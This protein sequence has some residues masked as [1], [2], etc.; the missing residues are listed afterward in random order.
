MAPAAVVAQVGEVTVVTDTLNVR[1]GP[2]T[3][4]PIIGK[5]TCGQKVQPNGKTADGSWWRIPFS[6]GNGFVFAQFATA[7]GTCGNPAAAA[8]PAAAPAAAPV[9]TTGGGTNVSV[10]SATLNVRSGPGL[11][12][13]ILGKLTQGQAIQATGKTTDGQWLQIVYNNGK[14]F[15]YA[16]YT[17]FATGT[18][19]PAPA[20]APAGA[21]PET[22]RGFEVRPPHP[23]QQEFPHLRPPMNVAGNSSQPAQARAPQASTLRQNVSPFAEPRKPV[24]APK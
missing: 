18:T 21:A 7:G 11:T 9:A 19:A 23:P 2:S 12:Y 6:N 5:L 16:A 17:S 8:V 13:D 15:V 10:T 4:D 20:A 1:S 3:G 24:A 22:G 14:A